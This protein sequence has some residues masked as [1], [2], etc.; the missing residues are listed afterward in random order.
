[1]TRIAIVIP[2]AGQSRRMRGDD[3]LLRRV[4]GT[5]LLRL[6]AERACAVSDD[7]IVTLPDAASPRAEVL[8]GLTVHRLPVPD[9]A[10]GMSSSLR[11][12]AAALPKG[13]DGLMILPADMP[14]ITVADLQT[15]L[16]AFQHAGNTP[17]VQA[18]SADGKP[19][20]PVL[21]PASCLPEFAALTGDTGA[22]SV[23]Q[24]HRNTLLR[25][26]LPE[27]HALTD[28]DTPEAWDAWRKANPDI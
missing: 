4:G 9:A 3:K 18:T 21:F 26:A 28:L 22:R 10:L 16:T 17:L 2:A 24:A 8:D 15:I 20:H 1:M 14:E 27:V 12:A 19:G 7:V 6:M 23:L 13:I 11:R 5:P 25:I